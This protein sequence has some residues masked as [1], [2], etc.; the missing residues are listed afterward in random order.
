MN[1]KKNP[2]RYHKIIKNFYKVSLNFRRT[3]LY[4]DN[5][6][7]IGQLMFRIKSLRFSEIKGLILFFSDVSRCVVVN[8]LNIRRPTWALISLATSSVRKSPVLILKNKFYRKSAV[9][10][11]VISSTLSPS[12]IVFVDFTRTFGIFRKTLSHI[13]LCWPQGLYLPRVF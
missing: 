1:L 13:L 11:Q 2:L 8:N 12:L 4:N 5:C 9:F 3:F 10:F 6:L 7:K